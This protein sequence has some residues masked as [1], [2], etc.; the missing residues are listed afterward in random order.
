MDA[1]SVGAIA[2]ARQ[3]AEAHG[4]T[5]REVE[6]VS[7]GANLLLHLQPAPLLAR[8]ATTTALVRRPVSAWLARDLNIAGF[9]HAQGVPVVPP[10]DLLPP[11]PHVN[12]GFTMSFWQYVDHDPNYTVTTQEAAG[13][14]R[15]LHRVLREYPPSRAAEL[16]LL[17]IFDEITRWMKFLEGR[18]A[19]LGI[20]LIA[21]REAHWLLAEKL[22]YGGENVQP[23]HGDAHKRN[24][25]KTPTGLLWTDFEDACIGPAAWD[26]AC[27][28]RT[29]PE[30]METALAAYP[31]APPWEEIAP[32]IEARTLEAVVYW[33]L[34]AERHPE[35]KREALERLELWR[36]G[37]GATVPVV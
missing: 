22:R 8:V 20:D 7:D 24:L 29:A 4:I 9:L 37:R 10:S 36:R 25:L 27:M 21:L 17:G 32:Y 14:L 5:V 13:L 15:E 3:V 1:L 30:G 34:Q 2:A 23:I 16:P 35:Q 26:I 31:D 11:G 12:D 18:R 28:I 19:L 6:V 33:Q